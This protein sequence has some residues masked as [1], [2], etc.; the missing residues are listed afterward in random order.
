M[1]DIYLQNYLSGMISGVNA[2]LISHPIDTIKTNIQEKK[3]ID[4]KF[5]S[6]YRGLMAPLLGVGLEKAI[7][8]GTYEVALKKTNNHA[9]S[10]GIAGLS[11]SFIVTPFS[12]KN[13]VFKTQGIINRRFIIRSNA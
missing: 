1:S 11:A 9:I 5:R 2:I 6:L 3:P 10:G 4:F 8:F 12:L 7:V 13:F